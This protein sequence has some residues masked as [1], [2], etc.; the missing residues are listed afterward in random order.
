MRDARRR[1]DLDLLQ[2]D[3]PGAQAIEQPDAAAQQH[4]RQID[5]DLVEQPGPNALL[6]DAGAAR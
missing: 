5:M 1:N 6:C 2:G 3:R 4:R